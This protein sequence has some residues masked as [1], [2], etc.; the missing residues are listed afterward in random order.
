MPDLFIP[1]EKVS[2]PRRLPVAFQNPGAVLRTAT[3]EW[4]R[5]MSSKYSGMLRAMPE[6]YEQGQF[7]LLDHSGW[8][9]NTET[10]KYIYD[11]TE[12]DVFERDLLTDIYLGATIVAIGTITEHLLDRHIALSEWADRMM[13]EIGVSVFTQY[14]LGIG[15]VNVIDQKGVEEAE[16][17]V[18]KQR[19]FF[20]RFLQGVSEGLLTFARILQRAR[21]YGESGTASYERA[22]AA[23]YGIV[24]PA[25]PGD[26]STVCLVMCRC[27][28]GLVDVDMETV[29]A[30]WNLGTVITEHCP[31][32]L[33]RAREWKPY[34][35]KREIEMDDDSS[36]DDDDFGSWFEDIEDLIP[37]DQDHEHHEDYL[38]FR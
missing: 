28:W 15:G 4:D 38:F 11:E 21:M 19:S 32:C 27:H 5:R 33:I 2:V 3:Q 20:Q 36:G 30:F 29:H 26:G 6:F 35:A 9:W 12:V 16:G 14:L 25:Y 17:Y 22:K 23:A 8:R 34:V 37:H 1:G 13:T 24:L 10:K 7:G 18:E 31:D